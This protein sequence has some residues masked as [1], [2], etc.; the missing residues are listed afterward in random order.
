MNLLLAIQTFQESI[1]SQSYQYIIES[2]LP[3]QSR[4]LIYDKWR[5]D[6]ILFERNSFIAKIYQDF[7]DNQS[8]ENFAKVIIANYLLESLYFYNGFNFFYLLASRNKMVGTSDII[9]LINRDELSHVVLFRS[10]VKEIKN[11]YPEFFSTETIYSMFNTAVEQEINWTEH[12]IG[13]RV[14]G[15]T[16]QTTE[17]YTKW[18]ANERLKSL[19]L[20]PLYSGFTKN[21]YKHLER[22][23][24]TEGEGNVKSNFF[25]GTVTSYNMSSSIDGWEDF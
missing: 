14:L 12:I 18:L 8:D 21:P 17:G 4:D 3:K 22:F 9:R 25:E 7:I 24:D 10:I 1:H 15:I 20:E 13:N 2:I 5:D 19:G 11:D 16:S 23:A 6:K